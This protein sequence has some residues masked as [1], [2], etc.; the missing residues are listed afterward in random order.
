MEGEG[1]MSVYGR[2]ELL[3][4][5]HNNNSLSIIVPA[6]FMFARERERERERAA[7]TKTFTWPPDS[8]V[9]MLYP[10]KYSTA[11]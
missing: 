7:E 5:S 4:L 10:L 1:Q 3:F 9:W 6:L 2:E 11:N 8:E